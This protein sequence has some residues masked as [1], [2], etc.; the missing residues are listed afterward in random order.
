M[1]YRGYED[2]ESFE[3]ISQDADTRRICLRM[4]ALAQN[5]KIGRFL[6]ELEVD[7]EVDA[8][9][10]GSLEELASN[11]SFLLAVEDYVHRTQTLH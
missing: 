9:T 10:R 7:G 2:L 5:G 8:A 4:A 11:P 3:A 6:N 1:V